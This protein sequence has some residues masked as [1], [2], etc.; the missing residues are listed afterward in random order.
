L[1]GSL[2]TIDLIKE[3][4]RGLTFLGFLEE[5]AE[6]PL[7]LSNPLGQAVRSFTHE[8]GCDII[9]HRR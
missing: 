3:D 8:E 5:Q 4:D 9:A 2:L 1:R 7:S 6:L